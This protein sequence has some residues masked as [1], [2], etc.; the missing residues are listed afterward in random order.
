VEVLFDSLNEMALAGNRRHFYFGLDPLSV[1]EAD[2]SVNGIL[3]LLPGAGL[4]LVDKRGFEVA[5]EDSMLA[6]SQQLPFLDMH[7][8]AL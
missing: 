4:E 1:V 8:T 6:L 2:I 3:Q 7:W 5:E